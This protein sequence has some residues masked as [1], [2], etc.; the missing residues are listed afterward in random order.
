MDI[1]ANIKCVYSGVALSGV[2]VTARHSTAGNFSGQTDEHG[3]L[4]LYNLPKGTYTFEIN[5]VGQPGWASYTSGTYTV[6][7]DQLLNCSLK[8]NYK[9]LTVKVKGFDAF[10]ETADSPLRNVTIRL[11]GLDPNDHDVVLVSPA[12]L[13]TGEDGTVTFQNL[14]PI[15]WRIEAYSPGYDSIDDVIVEAKDDGTL[16][17]QTVRLLWI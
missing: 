17:L 13:I 9:S 7:Q 4:V 11:Y 8:P 3:A 5:K 1:Y 16:M 6:T 12:P 2:T 14:V 15:D 10:S